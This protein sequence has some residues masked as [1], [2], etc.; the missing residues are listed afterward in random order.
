MNRRVLLDGKPLTSGVVM[1]WHAKGRAANGTIQ[2][3]GKFERT[4]GSTGDGAQT[5][6][7]AVT[8]TRAAPDGERELLTQ[9]H[10]EYTQ[11]G[12]FKAWATV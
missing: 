8:V 3:D 9:G 2:P 1:I 7:H 6:T 11:G 12:R 10:V 4:T 5:G